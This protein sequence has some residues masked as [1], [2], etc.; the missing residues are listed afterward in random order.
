MDDFIVLR[1]SWP[2][3]I[4]QRFFAPKNPQLAHNK[5]AAIR[6]KY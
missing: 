1:A 4:N 6:N 5:Y 2:S 3:E